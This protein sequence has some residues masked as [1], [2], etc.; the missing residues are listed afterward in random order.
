[1]ARTP[2][3][4]AHKKVLDAAIQLIE[5]RG[6]DGASM[7]AIAQLSGVSKATVYKHWKD[8]ETLCIDVLAS[9][10]EHPPEF[11]AGDLRRDLIDYLRYMFRFEKSDRLMKIW[12]KII[13]HAAANPNFGLA[14]QKHAF[15]P[16]RAQVARILARG[17]E[18]GEF[19]PE[20]DPNFAMDLLIGPIMHRRFAGNVLAEDFPEQVVDAV[21]RGLTR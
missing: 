19:P 10:R 21:L 4:T 8:K 12:P 13:G 1:V 15:E 6:I 11:D 7:D 18:R 2:S 3:A 14:L 16:R 9:L 20:V 17:A 5:E